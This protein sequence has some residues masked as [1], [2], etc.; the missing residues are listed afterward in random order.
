MNA[1]IRTTIAFS[2]L[3]CMALATG[4]CQ[5]SSTNKSD[6]ASANAAGAANPQGAASNGGA[7]ATTMTDEQRA[8]YMQRHGVGFSG[9]DTNSDGRI[10]MEEANAY[11]R[12]PLT[13]GGDSDHDGAMSAAELAAANPAVRAQL[14]RRDANGDGA[15]SS[16]EID[17]R[18]QAVFQATDTNHDGGISEQE[19]QAA[20][21][22]A[23][24]R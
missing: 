5:Q 23:P 18:V 21:A 13:S 15:V 8:A 10:T 3:T 12:G 16:A 11:A 6:T 4:A 14:L 20:T 19:Y 2:A 22:G 9:T 24:A 17:A 1:T 7:A